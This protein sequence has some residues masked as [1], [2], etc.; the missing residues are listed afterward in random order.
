MYMF[1]FDQEAL[2]TV[3]TTNQTTAG[4]SSAAGSTSNGANE[5]P[6]N[7]RFKK[8]V[9]LKEGGSGVETHDR[10]GREVGLKSEWVNLDE[11]IAEQ[12]KTFLSNHIG[13][14]QQL[15]EDRYRILANPAHLHDRLLFERLV[16]EKV[17]PDGTTERA[18]DKDQIDNQISEFLKTSEG[19][20][21]TL[22]I[23]EEQTA[24]RLFGMGL[25]AAAN[26][27]GHRDFFPSEVTVPLN[28]DQG[29]LNRQGRPIVE[30][31][32]QHLNGAAGRP[33]PPQGQV[34]PLRIWPNG[35]RRWHMGG[36]L[37]GI[38]SVGAA[39]G[40]V[41]GFILGGPPGAGVG[42]A[43]GGGVD[44]GA[45]AVWR[46]V[47]NGVMM[48]VRQTTAALNVIKNDPAEAEYLYKM[49]G[50]DVGD[51]NVVPGVAAVP[52]GPVGP[53]TIGLARE[54][55]HLETN[56][57]IDEIRKDASGM[58]FTRM[59]F[60]AKI[61]VPLEDV[62]VSPFSRLFNSQTGAIE[63]TGTRWQ[64][65]EQEIF[66]DLGGFRDGA[67]N[68]REDP[69][70]DLA[71]NGDD[72]EGN[73]RRQL[74]SERLAT[75]EMM[76]KLIRTETSAASSINNAKTSLAA[77]R[78]EMA[79]A[80]GTV[81]TPEYRNRRTENLIRQRGRIEGFR[82]SIT[83]ERGNFNSYNELLTNL[84]TARSNARNRFGTDNIADLQVLLN[85]I[86]EDRDGPIGGPPAAGSYR[87]AEIGMA[88]AETADIAAAQVPV[89]AAASALTPPQQPRN[90]DLERAAA[91]IRE[92]YDRLR[93]SSGLTRRRANLDGRIEPLENAIS[94]IQ[95]AEQALENEP[96]DLN[97]Q[98]E[99]VERSFDAV[100]GWNIP[101]TADLTQAALA[102]EDVDEIMRRVNATN[103]APPPGT[104]GWPEANNN[105]D[106]NRNRVIEAIIEARARDAMG[107]VNTTNPDWQGRFGTLSGPPY[108]YSANQLR[109][110]SQVEIAADIAT[111]T[112]PGVAA[113]E[114]DDA[115]SWS[116]AL[117]QQRLQVMENLD[118]NLEG[119]MGVIDSQTA[120]ANFDQELRM[121][122]T[123]IELSGQ[124]TQLI[125]QRGQIIEN[126]ATFTDR[127][128]I[129]GDATYTQSERDAA[130]LRGYYE[131][132]NF[133]FDYRER[134]DR[135]TYFRRVSQVLTP[136]RLRDFIVTAIPIVDNM[137]NTRPT[138]NTVF[139]RLAA[140]TT[141][142]NNIDDR[143][144]VNL[145]F[146]IE[147]TLREEGLAVE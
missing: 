36:I 143:D 63:Q 121:I 10:K 113:N 99:T 136:D 69:G 120:G 133:L 96:R 16:T 20:K 33:G 115:K 93:Q 14:L 52:G 1:Q 101:G 3:R 53:D 130:G 6:N 88:A 122:D 21:V 138:L 95:A 57:R 132:M 24:L 110:M 7:Y 105:A 107:V 4:E 134:T 66:N 135:D 8:N 27:E 49:T 89:R 75:T 41:G 18:V 64:D 85:P 77:K 62:D 86:Q 72:R 83:T 73:A 109:Y 38:S 45:A 82:G 68:G 118:R 58:I 46:G 67:G 106:A 87:A 37:T 91:P 60:Y 131:F 25:M 128:A 112:L 94:A 61:G 79:G 71:V 28:I 140:E 127:G 80:T 65:R 78:T 114:I 32:N 29:S 56:K 117:L 145:I 70:F 30:W 15:G 92:G 90:E 97:R 54:F 125:G 31:F 51:F 22:Q 26:P 40:A 108:N 50:I 103:A 11:H 19:W 142:T 48:E 44:W 74:Q 144:M 81:I 111:R 126:I 35:M 47:R 98:L 123:A 141:V 147:R 119:Q 84:A 100:S 9:F 42:A 139:Q 76:Q 55:V 13:N 129:A 116:D 59:E 12:F 137:G 102:T 146:L 124:Q 2:R 34:G 5:S 43:A 23:L 17:N 39:M 104:R